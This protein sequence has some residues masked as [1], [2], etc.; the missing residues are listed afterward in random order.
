VI[1]EA[2]AALRSGRAVILPTDTVYGLAAL[3]ADVRAVRA[4]YELKGRAPTQATALIAAD[5]R[6]V[7]DLVPELD[8]RARAC[9]EALLPGGYTLVLP[10]P[11]RRFPWLAGEHPDAIGVRVP[12]LPAAAETIV[13]LAGP[14][15]ATSAN[16]PG[17]RDPARL[18]EVPDALRA[19]A[20]VA[21][22]G[23]ELPG[24]A[25][26]VLDLT[27]AQPRVLRAGAADPAAA[28]G[29]LGEILAGK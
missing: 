29:R 24:T 20:A 5:V 22:D 7:F 25:S 9:V 18:A 4:L 11:S 16:D 3:A 28:L 14:V 17:G 12:V 15:A 21:V 26:T 19:G 23:G 27:G 8:E 2:V 6:T 13:R 1:D 10:N